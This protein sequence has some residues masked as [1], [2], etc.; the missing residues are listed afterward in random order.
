M[1]RVSFSS[2]QCIVSSNAGYVVCIPADGQPRL[3]IAITIF[4]VVQ[5]IGEG[6][7][8]QMLEILVELLSGRRT[9]S[10]NLPYL[11]KDTSDQ[12]SRRRQCERARW[13]RAYLD[14]V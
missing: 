3:A 14:H 10:A 9:R 13:S 1:L 7:R 11:A 2:E 4:E 6:G 12:L 8:K 5:D